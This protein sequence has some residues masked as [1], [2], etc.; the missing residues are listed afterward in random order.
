MTKYRIYL[1]VSEKGHVDAGKRP[2]LHPLPIA[3]YQKPL[4]TV[5]IALDLDIPKE[6]FEATRI[7]LDK[8]IEQSKPAVEISEVAH[9][10]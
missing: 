5:L 7:L 10:K 6:Q 8:K 3:K 2:N 1:R 9:D 4:P